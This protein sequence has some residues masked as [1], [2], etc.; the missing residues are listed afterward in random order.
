MSVPAHREG[1]G[2]PIV[3]GQRRNRS[4][5]IGANVRKDVEQGMLW[6]YSGRTERD[7]V[8]REAMGRST[9]ARRR[10]DPEPLI[11]AGIC[12]EAEH[13]LRRRLEA[14]PPQNRGGPSHQDIVAISRTGAPTHLRRA[15]SASATRY[16]RRSKRRQQAPGR[17]VRGTL[18]LGAW[19]SWTSPLKRVRAER[20]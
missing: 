19:L 10:S 4:P 18:V 6:H 1:H 16:V 17:G 14:Y 2:R 9:F 5:L 12:K 7:C 20:R 15:V 8:Q 13:S 3:A 11:G